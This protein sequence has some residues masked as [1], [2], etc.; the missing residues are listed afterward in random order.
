MAKHDVDP[1]LR[2][3]V[4]SVNESA[5][6]AIPVT[7]AVHGMILDGE[8][9]SQRRYFAELTESSPLV[10]AL[11]PSSGLLGKDYA[12]DADAEQDHYL[13]LRGAHLQPK[14]AHSDGLW[15]VSLRAVDGWNL[16]G[17]AAAGESRQGPFAGLMG[18]S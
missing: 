17:L 10:A 6:A 18:A 13:H 16:H 5:Q 14:A 7:V 3:L 15:R 8:L 1:T 9:I 2:E 4:H 12:Q 11:D